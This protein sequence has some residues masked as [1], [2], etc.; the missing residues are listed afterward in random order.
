[1]ADKK[2]TSC[3]HTGKPEDKWLKCPECS[4]TMCHRCGDQKRKEQSDL[5]TLRTGHARERIRVLCPNCEHHLS[6]F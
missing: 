2:C 4:Y 3:G 5:E 1:M 6:P